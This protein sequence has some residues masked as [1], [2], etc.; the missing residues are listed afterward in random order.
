VE[1]RGARVLDDSGRG[2]VVV[3]LSDL[4]TLL[5]VGSECIAGS[6]SDDAL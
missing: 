1:E 4:T 6:G 5:D 2:V 3:G